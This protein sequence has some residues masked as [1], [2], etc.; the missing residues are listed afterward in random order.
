MA[1]PCAAAA[2]WSAGACAGAPCD[3]SSAWAGALASAAPRRSSV[4]GGAAGAFTCAKVTSSS[5]ADPGGSIRAR[6][7]CRVSPGGISGSAGRAILV[8]TGLPAL[9][10][11]RICSG[12]AVMVRS[13]M[14]RIMPETDRAAW[15]SWS[16]GSN[17][18]PSM[19]RPTL[20][21]GRPTPAK[22]PAV[23]GHRRTTSTRKTTATAIITAKAAAMPAQTT[24]V[25]AASRMRRLSCALARKALGRASP[26]RGADSGSGSAAA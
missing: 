20:L 6:A 5:A 8:A 21:T 10:S 24:P 25:V 7:K 4:S 15:P 13:S 1:G 3:G 2:T 22:A 12:G 19:A 17:S 14:L 23:L 18:T 26:S 11:R 9:F 16:A